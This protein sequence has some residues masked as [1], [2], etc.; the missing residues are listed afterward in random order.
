MKENQKENHRHRNYFSRH[1]VGTQIRT[2]YIV[3]I[4][5]PILII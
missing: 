1:N 3:A 5:I 4:I 2:L